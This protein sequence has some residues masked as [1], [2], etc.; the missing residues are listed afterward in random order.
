MSVVVEELA[1]LAAEKAARDVENGLGGGVHL[2]HKSVLVES[3]RGQAHRID[4]GG[5]RS[6]RSARCRDGGDLD[7][8]PGKGR[9]AGFRIH[10]KKV[11]FNSSMPFN[12]S[13]TGAVLDHL[14]QGCRPLS[15]T[16]EE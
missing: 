2:G 4:R 14:A 5:W 12:T 13:M 3:D 9:I 1:R 8:A 10:V 16:R 11:H 15:L 6:A 7:Q